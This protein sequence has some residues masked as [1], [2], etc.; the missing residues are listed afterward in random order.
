MNILR[1]QNFDIKE[2]EISY[3][4]LVVFPTDTVYRIG[5]NAY[6]K[7]ACERIYE[8]KGSEIYAKK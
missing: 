7:Q 2:F 6:N 1:P 3:L 8:V 5:T 4:R